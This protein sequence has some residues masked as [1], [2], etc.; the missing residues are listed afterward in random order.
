[1]SAACRRFPSP[2]SPPWWTRCG[3]RSDRRTCPPWQAAD[4]LVSIGPVR[5]LRILI[6]GQ[7]EFGRAALQAFLEKGHS[8]AGVFCAPDTPG[9]KPDPLKEAALAAGVPVHQFASL[10]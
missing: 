6:I 3:E 4:E 9:M 5:H 7:S 1:M 10:R 8:I 2:R